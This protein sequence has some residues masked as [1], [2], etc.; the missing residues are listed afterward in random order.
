Q[1]DLAAARMRVGDATPQFL[2]VEV[3]AGE[4]ARVGLVAEARVDRIGARVDRGLQGRQV[5]CGTYQL[6]QRLPVWI[7]GGCGPVAGCVAYS[8]DHSASTRRSTS[9]SGWIGRPHSRS[10]SPGHLR[11]ASSPSFE[12]RPATGEAKSR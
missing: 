10:D 11:V 4:R 1:V 2:L 12:P 8:C 7:A 6:H 3:Q 5:A 9:A